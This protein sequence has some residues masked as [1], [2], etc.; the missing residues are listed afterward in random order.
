[1]TS[2]L[3]EWSSEHLNMGLQPALAS[4]KRVRTFEE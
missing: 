2:P 4:L 3:A 1:V